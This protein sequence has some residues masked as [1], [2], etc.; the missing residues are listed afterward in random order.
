MSY[1]R[2]AH[3]AYIDAAYTAGLARSRRAHR[4]LAAA[5]TA[6]GR[7]LSVIYTLAMWT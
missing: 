3:E 2:S 7:C 5:L 6:A 1:W 4:C